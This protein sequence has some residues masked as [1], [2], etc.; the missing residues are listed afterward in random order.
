MLFMKAYHAEGACG[1]QGACDVCGYG[2]W[3]DCRV[4]VIMLSKPPILYIVS[5]V[6]GV[7][8]ACG[9]PRN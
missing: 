4:L 3:D 9:G 1:A 2:V 6:Y 5:G 8:G 7:S